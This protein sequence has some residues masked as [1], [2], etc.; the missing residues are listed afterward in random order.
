M[1]DKFNLLKLSDQELIEK[2]RQDSRYLGVV[3]EKYK[4]ACMIFLNGYSKK[5]KHITTEDVFSESCFQLYKNII[6]KNLELTN[7]SSLQTYLNSICLNQLRN[8]LGKELNKDGTIKS[9]K[10]TSGD[11]SEKKDNENAEIKDRMTIRDSNNKTTNPDW[12]P[13]DISN[14]K[15]YSDASQKS[16]IK[17]ALF[18]MKADG[19]HCAELLVLFWWRKRSMKEL[20][21]I[22]GYTNEVNTRNQKARCQKRLKTIMLKEL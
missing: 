9:T 3:H 11:G 22:F 6:H 1:A 8:A 10:K 2:M 18:K 19:G 13:D 14:D 5:L 16:A 20:T 21:E 4:S 17:K 15:D 12:L 7:N